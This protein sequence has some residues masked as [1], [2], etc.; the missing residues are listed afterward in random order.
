MRRIKTNDRSQFRLELRPVFYAREHILCPWTICAGGEAVTVYAD[1][2]FALNAAVNAFLL[3]ASARLGGGQIHPWRLA[4]AGGMGGLY[5]VAALLPRLGFL[6][7]AGMKLVLLA[8]MLLCAFG[9]RRRTLRLGV[10][11]LGLGCCFAGLVL[12]GVHILGGE[13]FLTPSG[14]FYPVSAAMLLLLA[15]S[16][17]F[18]C[19]LAFSRLAEHGGGEIVSLRLALGGRTAD[20]RALRDSGNT[21]RDPLTNERVLVA[22]WETAQALLPQA[23]LAPLRAQGAEAAMRHLAV[24]CPALHPR[25]IPY[26]AVGT[27]AGLLLALRCTVLAAGQ[28]PKRVLVAFSPTPLSDGGNYNALTGGL[29]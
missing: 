6:Q 27:R 24:L 26:R 17:Y 13:L 21:L 20:I 22:E 11:F 8:G 16:A 5:A 2:L 7:T 12:I 25:L 4:A 1:V 23:N 15:A 18:L 14:A 29:P 3:L 9:A 28:K 19:E 10:L